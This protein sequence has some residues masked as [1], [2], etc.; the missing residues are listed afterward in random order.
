MSP[1]PVFASRNYIPA[2]IIHVRCLALGQSYALNGAS[3]S[4]LAL[5]HRGSDLVQNTSHPRF[6]AAIAKA[7]NPPKLFPTP[8][9]LVFLKSRLD[10]LVTQF[11]AL[12]ELS[13]AG[14]HQGAAR[15]VA[16][17]TQPLIERL[18]DYPS[19]DLDLHNIVAYPPKIEP[20]P[21]KPLF[22][23]LAW[24]YIDYPGRQTRS[25]NGVFEAASKAS[26]K[27]DEKKE[28][29]KGWFSFGR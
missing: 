7:H 4:A 28:A 10:N 17:H 18:D 14:E 20:V 1:L 25:A 23:D 8:E 27:A 12:V 16:I 13:H 19:T 11:R 2:L 24:N 22:F 6:S 3:V 5:F 29:R 9:S 15:S 21:V 26:V